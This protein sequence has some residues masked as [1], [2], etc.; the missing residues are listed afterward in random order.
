MNN[1]INAFNWTDT[2]G[3]PSGGTVYG[4]GFSISWQNGPLGRHTSAC[5]L[6]GTCSANCTRV[7]PNGAFVEDVIAAVRQRLE[8]YQ[9]SKF[10]CE[11]NRIALEHLACAADVLEART[12]AREA[13][14]V[15]GTY[16]K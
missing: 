7:P 14:A 15:E 5:M 16:A 8:Y 3:N 2:N 11:E 12:K 13:R 6:N 9:A 10:H 1:P 4:N